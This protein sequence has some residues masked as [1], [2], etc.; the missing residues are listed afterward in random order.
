LSQALTDAGNEDRAR[1][2]LGQTDV[3]RLP[4]RRAQIEAVLAS[5]P[6]LDAAL[7]TSRTSPTEVLKGAQPHIATQHLLGLW[8][9]LSGASHGDWWAG[10]SLS[11][12]TATGA[13]RLDGRVEVSLAS[14]PERVILLYAVVCDVVR[15][16]WE[17]WDERG[18]AHA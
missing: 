15:T 5:R 18:G 6:E 11:T 12:P 10:L 14:T 3:E 1:A 8:N 13:P 9:A 17:L 4:N 2:N 16:G 7:A